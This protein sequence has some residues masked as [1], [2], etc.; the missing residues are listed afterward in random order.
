[1]LTPKILPIKTIKMVGCKLLMNLAEDKTSLLWEM[2]MSRCCNIKKRKNNMLY[3]IQ[4]YEKDTNFMSFERLKKYENWAA[5][6]VE[7]FTDIPQ[8]LESL[9]VPSG[10]YAR[11][12]YQGLAANFSQ[13]LQQMIYDWLV[14][15]PFDIDNR[16]HFMVMAA[17]YSPI[18]FHA[19]EEVWL[20]IQKK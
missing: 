16:P 2:F 5:V 1:M 7:S 19:Q 18:D 4:F 10:L 6:E 15:S 9:I 11:F 20:P 17:D 8:G 3:S 14:K 12:I 13:Y